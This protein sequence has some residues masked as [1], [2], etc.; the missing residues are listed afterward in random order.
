VKEKEEFIELSGKPFLYWT[1]VMPKSKEPGATEKQVYL[2]AI[3]F[4][5]LLILNGPVGNG[6]TEEQIRNKLLTIA[7]TLTLNPNQVQDINK[8]YTELKK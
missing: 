2:V 5:Q 1:Y 4:D 3:C 8:L 7:R 6:T